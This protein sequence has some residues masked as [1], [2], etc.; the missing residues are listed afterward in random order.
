VPL[1]AIRA[2]AWASAHEMHADGR[3]RGD[4][5]CP[6]SEMERRS[7]VA[8]LHRVGTV[9]LVLNSNLDTAA[10]IGILGLPLLG[11]APGALG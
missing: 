3:I 2:S 6:V 1:F 7:F 5:G 4:K 9:T 8:W 11:F 10:M